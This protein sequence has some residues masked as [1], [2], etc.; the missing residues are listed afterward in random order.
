MV[1]ESAGIRISIGMAI[2]PLRKQNRGR[3]PSVEGG[4]VCL[5]REGGADARFGALGASV[6]PRPNLFRDGCAHLGGVGLSI[7][8]SAR[9]G[10]MVSIE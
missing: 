8:V 4:F 7:S 1:G 2:A 9:L 6:R 5:R 3:Q 10:E